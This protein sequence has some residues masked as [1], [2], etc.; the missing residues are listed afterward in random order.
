MNEKPLN[1]KSVLAKLQDYY[2]RHRELPSTPAMA[3]LLNTSEESLM[4]VLQKLLSAGVLNRCQKS[5]D[6]EPADAFFESGMTADA[7]PAGTP[8]MMAYDGARDS[9]NIHS[10]LIR[11]PSKT[12]MIPVTGDSMKDAGICQGDLAVVEMGRPAMPNDIVIAKVD[13]AYTLKRLIKEG[14]SYSLRPENAAYQD[15][16]PEGE[17]EI[18]G[19]MVGLARRYFH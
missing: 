18:L 15:I 10:Y 3:L 1:E 19:V 5:K 7:I 6:I 9:V 2:A 17:L 11:H 14:S 8:A 4:P 12:L 13:G 16:H